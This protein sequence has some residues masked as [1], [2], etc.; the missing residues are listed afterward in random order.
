MKPK[1]SIITVCYNCVST[2]ER[3]IKS[4]LSQDYPNIEYIVIDGKSTDGTMDAIRRY[5]QSISFF[6]S[7][8]DKGIYDA[9]N[10]GIDAATGELIGFINGD[11]YYAE[12]AISEIACTYEA[13]GADVIYGDLM[14]V[15]VNGKQRHENYSK[16]VADI[17]EF[18]F[19]M[20]IPHSGTFC[21][22]ELQKKYKMDVGYQIA[23]DYKFLLQLYH[24]KK[25]FVYVG[26]ILSFFYM[27]GISN[28]KLFKCAKESYNISILAIKGNPLLEEKYREKIENYF[29]GKIKDLIFERICKYDYIN[30][31]AQE[32]CDAGYQFFIFGAGQRA[33]KIYQEYSQRKI[34]INGFLDNNEKIHGKKIQGIEIIS[35]K[36]L[37]TMGQA[38]VII[39]TVKYEKE[40]LNQLEKMKLGDKFVFY[41]G[42]QMWQDVVRDYLHEKKLFCG[43]PCCS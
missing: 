18:Y 39:S 25:K 42:G 8:P 15:D 22:T 36:V 26:K 13:T 9:M 35:P 34:P 29:Q 30:Q 2:I 10:K 12:N 27:G 21:K 16:S 14:L 28:S 17:D 19:R 40:I 37:R 38:I 33:K 7:E 1:I 32:K 5:E 41:T 23:S 43:L 20:M 3:T 11:D 24:E 4:V 31:W 6:L